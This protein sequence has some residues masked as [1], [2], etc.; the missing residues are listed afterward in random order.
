ME[1]GREP[2]EWRGAV[3][4]EE[5]EQWRGEKDKP[6]KTKYVCQWG[7]VLWMH[8]FNSFKLITKIRQRFS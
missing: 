4:E 7:Q 3:R 5:K 6:I 1:E 8:I 2:L